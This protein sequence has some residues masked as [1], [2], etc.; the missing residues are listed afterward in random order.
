VR[1]D[2]SNFVGKS[3]GRCPFLSEA[4]RHSTDCVKRENSLGVC[5]VNA[6][7]NGAAQDW[8]ACPYRVISSDLVRSACQRIFGQMDIPQPI[9]VTLLQ[10]PAE[11][12]NFK[13][14]VGGGTAGYVFFQDKLGGEISVVGTPR[15]PEMS[16]DVTLV[17]IRNQA[18]KFTARMCSR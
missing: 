1:L 4:L 6:A 8:L 16:F 11:L 5:T 17:E 12:A 10:I 15:S 9:P 7:S 18:G 13:K 3:F 14:R 2:V